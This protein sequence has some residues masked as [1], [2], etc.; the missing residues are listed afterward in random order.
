MRRANMY[1]ANLALM[2][3]AIPPLMAQDSAGSRPENRC[4]FAA[5]DQLPKVPGLEIIRHEIRRQQRTGQSASLVVVFDV[6]ALG[7]EQRYSYACSAIAGSRPQV[8]EVFH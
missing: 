2:I 5:A 1:L 8:F 6:R 4:V 3:S 7:R